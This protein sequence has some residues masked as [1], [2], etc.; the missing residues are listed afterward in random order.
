MLILVAGAAASPLGSLHMCVAQLPLRMV[1]FRQASC[2]FS[3]KIAE[4]I[5]VAVQSEFC[6]D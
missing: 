3:S 2:T 4:L 6:I 1:S 5:T